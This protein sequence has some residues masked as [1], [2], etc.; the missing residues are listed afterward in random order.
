[1][2]NAPFTHLTTKQLIDAYIKHPSQ[3]LLLFGPVG[4][5]LQALAEFIAKEIVRHPTDIIVIA[6]DE[7]GT[8]SIERVRAL[9][10][11]T[12]DYRSTKLAVL[13]DDIDAMSSDAQN[14]FLKLLEEP[15]ASVHFIAT[16]HYPG[17]L[18]ATIES[19]VERIPVQTITTAE[20]QSL[21]HSKHVTNS[22]E[23]QQMLFLASGLPAELARL[24]DNREYFNEAAARVRL[25]RDFLSGKTY[26]RLA[27]TS[28]ISL[29]QDAQQFVDILAKLVQSI[30][31]TQL[32]SIR[33]ETVTALEKTAENLEHN[34]HVKTQL[35][36]LALHV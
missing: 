22:T 10:V 11:E 15:N 7:R 16:T 18:L 25:A 17:K 27:I 29:R 26:D 34:G 23:L 21:L 30:G 8:I 9:Y 20:S 14:A 32:S 6:P 13:I 19:R 4:V 24:A 31:N 2:S 5:G 3:S 1:M 33:D 12:R 28:R 36:Y 35:M